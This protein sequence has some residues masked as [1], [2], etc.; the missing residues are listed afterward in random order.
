MLSLIKMHASFCERDCFGEL[1]LP[2]ISYFQIV[3]KSYLCAKILVLFFVS[4]FLLNICPT[5]LDIL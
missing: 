2:Q 5:Q 3:T 1:F 4:Y